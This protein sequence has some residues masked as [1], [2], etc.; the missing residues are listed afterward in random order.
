MG[1][2]VRAAAEPLRSSLARRRQLGEGAVGS[3]QQLVELGAA[4]CTLGRR[5]RPYDLERREDRVLERRLAVL[6]TA[7]PLFAQHGPP[8]VA[9]RL[10]A[11]VVRGADAET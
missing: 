8:R 1:K 4:A 6:E 5:H 2:I 3:G 7:R 11:H 9:K 10:Q